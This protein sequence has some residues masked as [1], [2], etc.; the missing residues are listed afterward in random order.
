[1]SNNNYELILENVKAIKKQKEYSK[2]FLEQYEKEKEQLIKERDN[3]SKIKDQLDN[4]LFTCKLILEKITFN[5]KHK[6]EKFLTYA[7]QNI[8]V[9]RHYAI[10]I[11]LKEDTKKPGLE[12]T[13]V[14]DGQ[15]QEITESVGGGIISTLGLLLQIYYIEVY[16]LNKIMFIDEGL[17]EVSTDQTAYGYE[18][19]NYLK[20]IMGFLKWLSNEKQYKFVIVTHDPQIKDFADTFYEVK[21]GSVITC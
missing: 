20:N 3:I 21:K 19:I 11:A 17:K 10:E 16:K 18:N 5:S 1:M 14:E 8:F 7:F 12:L 15:K 6:L 4:L 9:D 13:L 2:I